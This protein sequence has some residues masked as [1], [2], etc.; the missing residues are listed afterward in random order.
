MLLSDA[1]QSFLDHRQRRRRLPTT[2]EQYSYQLNELWQDWRQRKQYPDDLESIDLAEIAAYFLYLEKEHINR[3]SG[4]IGLSPAT[5]ESAWRIIRCFWRYSGRRKWLSPEQIEL[6]QDDEIL[7]RPTLDH[8]IRPALDDGILES[9]LQACTTLLDLEERTRNR[10]LLLLLAETGARVGEMANLAIGDIHLED[11]CARVIGKG[12]REEWIFWNHRG[13]RALA[14]YLPHRGDL[15]G[16]LFRRLTG[17]PL[18]IDGI[19]QTLKEMAKIAGVT[20][21]PG[22][23]VHCFRHRFAHKALERGLDVSQ[24][25]QLMRHRHPSTTYRY[26]QENKDRLRR[27]R[28]KMGD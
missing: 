20:L 4:A 3:R 23:S 21:P 16:P 11:R 17:E 25:A 1:I 27:I 26:L 19:R 24:V 6:F 18:R 12:N 13:A 5:R 7:A 15:S 14:A 28:D 9:L 2:I 8:R 22:A 10:A